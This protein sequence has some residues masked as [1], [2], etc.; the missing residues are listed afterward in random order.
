MDGQPQDPGRRRVLQAGGALVATAVTASARP[1][2]A[3]EGTNPFPWGVASFDPTADA[4]LIWTRVDPALGDP[5]P[6]TWAVAADE[7]LTD[8]IAT[9]IVHAG[10]L[11]G[12]CV[13]VD[14]TGLPP[15]TTW[16][17]RFSAP[18]GTAS[19]VGRT[20]TVPTEAVERLRLG[21]ASCSRYASGGFAAYRAL[22]AHEV[23]LV[24]HVGDYIYEDGRGG[25]RA[26]E[27]STALVT[28]DQYRTRYAQHRLDPDLQALHARHPVVAVWDDH[29][30]AGNAWRE[31]AAEHDPEVH[32]PWIERLR[33]AGQAHEEWLPGRTGRSEADGRLRAWRSLPLGGLAELVVLDTR[34]WGRDA[35]PTN[36]EDLADETPDAHRSMLGEDQMAFVASRLDPAQRPPWVVLANQVMFHPMAVP[37]P[38]PSLADDA[39]DAGF[40]V[41]GDRAVNPDQWT[42]TPPPASGWPRPS[43]G[44]AAWWW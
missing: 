15:A 31:G 6:L 27:P 7:A 10:R 44:P 36:P 4:V 38:M 18:D 20:R 41:D 39:R 1:S 32:G 2:T 5:V 22:A 30:V 8:I 23:D 35:Q 11:T 42:A 13:T 34:T 43:A 29:E 25:A 21:V 3:Q 28:V 12:H 40:L 14:A 24:V 26:H 37:V 33:A 9:G 17:Y 16:W 19:A